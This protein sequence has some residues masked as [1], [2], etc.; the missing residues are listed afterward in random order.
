MVLS[1]IGP[2]EGLA[3][4]VQARL[5]ELQNGPSAQAPGKWFPRGSKNEV[6]LGRQPGYRA[7]AAR[8]AP[9]KASMSA[10]PTEPEGGLIPR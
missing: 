10:V 1:K 5:R 7:A 4:A 8:P 2:D 6:S 3:R 9:G